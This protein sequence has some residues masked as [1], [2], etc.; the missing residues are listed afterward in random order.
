MVRFSQTLGDGQ[1]KN[2]EKPYEQ[3]RDNPYYI[4]EEKQPRIVQMARD[5]RMY[6]QPP[7]PAY[8]QKPIYQTWLHNN[9]LFLSYQKQ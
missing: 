6:S 5:D 2:R 9:K 3:L 1:S 8:Q 7:R 4:G